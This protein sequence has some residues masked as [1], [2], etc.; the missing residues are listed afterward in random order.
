LKK[1]I[2]ILIPV[3]AVLALVISAMALATP[4]MADPDPPDAT[5][6]SVGLSLSVVDLDGNVIPGAEVVVGDEVRFRMMLSIADVPPGEVGVNYEGGT[7]A[8]KINGHDYQHVAGYP[9]TPVTTI[10]KV[11]ESA[12]FI[13]ITPFTYTVDEDDIGIIDPYISVYGDYGETARFPDGEYGTYLFDP[14]METASATASRD[15]LVLV[16]ELTVSKTVETSYTRTHEWDIEKWVE[17]ENGYTIEDDIPKIWLW[18]DESGDEWA[19][20]HVCVEYLGY[21][22][23]DFNVSGEVTIENTGTAD[24]VITG[25]EDLLCGTAIDVD[26]GVTFPYTL[27]VGDT[28]V[29][30]YDEDVADMVIDCDNVVTVTTERGEYG[31]SEPVVWGDPDEE[32]LDIVDIEDDSDLFGLQFLGTLYADDYDEGDVECFTYDRFFAWADYSAPG[33]YIYENTA[34]IVQTG[35]SADARLVVNWL[36]EE[37]IVSKTVDTS[38][39]RT[40]LWDIEKWVETENGYT[41]EDDI[42]K[43]WLYED[44]SGDEWA[45]WHVCVEYLGYEDSNF[46]VSGEVTIENVGGSDAVIT[47][48]EDLLCGT[49]IDVDFGAVTFPYTLV[50]GG[51]LVGTYDEDVAGMV[52]DCDN[53]VTVTTEVDVYGTSESVMWGDPD[54]EFLDVVNI[55][56]VSDLFGTQA[57]G[58]LYAADYV[59]GDVECFTYDEFFAWADYSAPGPYTYDD[60]AT[61][62]E[63][64]QSA[65]A[66][67][68]V[69]W[70]QP[71]NEGCTP[72]F[73]KNNAKNWEAVAWLPTGYLPG[74]SFECVFGVDVMLRGKGKATY[75][76]PTLLE[77]LDANGGGIN[78]L[79]RH[80]VAAL[81]NISH[82]DIAYAGGMNVAGLIADVQEAV[83]SGEDAID[84]LHLLLADYNEAGCSINQHG[85]PI[86]DGV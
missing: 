81:L 31:T 17:T 16:E 35:Q 66:R 12:P 57:L 22:D 4:A 32:Y 56:D 43:I 63:T 8:L 54:E 44:E 62:V 50:V 80:A 28:L 48:V 47:G 41:I 25:V 14:P 30:T 26:F 72:G 38:Y 68:V 21:E 84:A 55:E 76:A 7:L 20:W 75:P 45:T 19:T 46:N 27:G 67:L 53:V 49:A 58:T 73:W 33:P 51:T 15:M 3:L 74:D 24:A 69:N 37:L 64:G 60:T 52:V 10:P 71:G 5:T 83:A 11:T 39:T 61:I 23:S 70:E 65:D 34:T 79:A 40:H 18:E 78:A 1:R 29:G 2:R 59:A 77:A 85:E 9:D 13:V 36:Y 86:M 42:P 82:P 6:G